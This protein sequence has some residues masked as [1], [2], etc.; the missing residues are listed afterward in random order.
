[1]ALTLDVE[2]ALNHLECS[3]SLV[4]Y[5]DLDGNVV[6][7]ALECADCYSVLADEDL[8]EWL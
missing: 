8:V 7:V 6:N 2:T 4:T 1:M 3:V 5:Q